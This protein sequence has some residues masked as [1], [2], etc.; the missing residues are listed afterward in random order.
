MESPSLVTQ[1]LLRQL[2][3]AAS[4]GDEAAFTELISAEMPRAYRAA[5]AVLTSPHDAEEAIQE[6]SLQAWR[7]ISQ[8]RE[9]EHWAAWFRRIAVR[10]SLDLASHTR[11]RRLRETALDNGPERTGGDPTSS[12]AT[13]A[14]IFAALEQLGLD[15]RMILGLRYGADLEMDDL[16]AALRIPTGTAKSR[17]HRALKRL[18]QQLGEL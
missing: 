11:R 8:L 17:L 15:D 14:S 2:V 3:K 13:R 7:E 1:G 4:L 9:P 18:A 16:A 6:A 5:L 10:K 12:W